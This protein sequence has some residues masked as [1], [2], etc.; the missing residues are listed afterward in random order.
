METFNWEQYLLNYPDLVLSGINNKFNAWRHY[1]RYGK[2][3]KRSDKLNLN[4]NTTKGNLGGRLGNVLFYN[5]IFSYLSTF[6]NLQVTYKNQIET[7]TILKIKLF[8]SGKQVFPKTFVLT[9]ENIDSVMDTPEIIKDKNLIIGGYFQTSTVARYIRSMIVP[10]E[11]KNECIF[12]HVRLGDIT[13][14]NNEPLC[15]YQKAISIL[16]K[17]R[18]FI[19]SDSIDHPICKTLIDQF[20]LIPFN[21]T[22]TE[23]ITFASC[24]KWLVLS[25]GTFSWWMGILSSGEVFYPNSSKKWHGDIFIFSDWKKITV[26]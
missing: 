9:D 21:G 22:E 23:T 25:K 14:I 7:E 4:I 1:C 24:C 19:T 17:V 3:E 11:V 8:D 15:Y 16:P 2:R 5:I 20:A 26:N 18:G 10:N 12:V 13:G 6:S